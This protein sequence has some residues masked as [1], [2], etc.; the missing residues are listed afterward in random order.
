MA[1]MPCEHLLRRRCV[2]RG[3][4]R[5]VQPACAIPPS[6]DPTATCGESSSDR[7]RTLRADFSS[8][9]PWTPHCNRQPSNIII[10]VCD[11][12]SRGTC[13]NNITCVPPCSIRQEG[14]PV[15][16]GQTSDECQATPPLRSS[17]TTPKACLPHMDSLFQPRNPHRA[18]RGPFLAQANCI[19]ANPAGEKT[20]KLPACEAKTPPRRRGAAGGK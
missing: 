11:I 2:K 3:C 9:T 13:N 10:V 7:N 6:R 15:Q 20:N 4:S 16:K 18:A 8:K 12:F 19:Q 14:T 1:M 17:P 5:M